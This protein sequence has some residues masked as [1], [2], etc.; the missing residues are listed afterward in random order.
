MLFKGC[1]VKKKCVMGIYGKYARIT[2]DQ[3]TTTLGYRYSLLKLHSSRSAPLCHYI[4]VRDLLI[5]LILLEHLNVKE[6]F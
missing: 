3:L 1:F 4:Y 5:D 2:A 6:P